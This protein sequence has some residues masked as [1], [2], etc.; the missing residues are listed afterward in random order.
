M[1]GIWPLLPSTPSGIWVR[2]WVPGWGRLLFYIGGIGPPG[3]IVP[4]A[5]LCT[6][7]LGIEIA[8][9]KP[10]KTAVV[11]VFIF[12]QKHYFSLL[13]FNKKLMKHLTLWGLC[14]LLIISSRFLSENQA[15]EY[16]GYLIWF[17]QILEPHTG[18]FDQKF[19]WKV[20]C[21]T[22]ARGSPPPL[23]L[24]IDRCTSD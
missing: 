21:S 19:F 12:I 5:R 24:N 18:D 6:G 16:G 10:W 13:I 11:F 2:N 7:H 22:Y 14:R 20:K 8:R 4:N 17:D 3:N 15:L 1:W 23:R 9:L